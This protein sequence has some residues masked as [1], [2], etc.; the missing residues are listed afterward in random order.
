[1]RSLVEK[2]STIEDDEEEEDLEPHE[3]PPV[4]PKESF[5]LIDRLMNAPLTDSESRLLR[6]MSE[7]F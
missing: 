2:A 7:R 4:T 3:A 6:S 5:Q 1:M